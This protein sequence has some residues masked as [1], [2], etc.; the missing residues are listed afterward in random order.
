MWI[1]P[2]SLTNLISASVIPDLSPSL[3]VQV[4]NPVRISPGHGS[5]SV[6]TVVCCQVEVTASGS[7]RVQ[8]SPAECGVSEWDQEALTVRRP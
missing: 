3:I 2:F 1:L 6:V 7:S 5:L 8:R 4:S